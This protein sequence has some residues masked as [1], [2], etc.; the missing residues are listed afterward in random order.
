MNTNIDI[1]E[2]SFDYLV[3][4]NPDVLV[5][6]DIS[7]IR[8]YMA[9]TLDDA[10]ITAAPVHIALFRS[11]FP[12][13]FQDD[14]IAMLEDVAKRQAGFAV[15]TS[16]LD[17]FQHA[18]ERSSI[19]I[20]VA[21]PKPLVE[22]QRNLLQ[23]FELKPSSFKPHIL[24]AGRLPQAQIG[25]LMPRLSQQLFVRSFNCHCFSLLRK[26]VNGGKFE[27]VKDLSLEILSTW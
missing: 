1:A 25:Q 4:V 17:T 20:N 3:V 5:T 19:F 16:K 9:T 22:L 18:D 8:Q 12:E 11:V 14:F 6:K 10:A 27:K 7:R 15:Y 23:E 21:N 24:V 13:R 2:A 26:P